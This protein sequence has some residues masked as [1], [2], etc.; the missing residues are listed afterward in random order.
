M[1]I[2]VSNNM[3]KLADSGTAFNTDTLRN[4]AGTGSSFPDLL[5]SQI[6]PANNAPSP[7]PAADVARARQP[8][9]T[10]PHEPSHAPASTS[11]TRQD[12]AHGMPPQHAGKHGRQPVGEKPQDGATVPA[13]GE[14]CEMVSSPG[15][16]VAD[17]AAPDDAIPDNVVAALTETPTQ[18]V[19]TVVTLVLP[20]TIAALPETLAK[21][22][23]ADADNP[24]AED[25][26]ITGI[27]TPPRNAKRHWRAAMA[28]NTAADPAGSG[29]TG[30]TA[31]ASMT[32]VLTA[33]PPDSQAANIP[34][35]RA[36]ALM[37][38][39][40][41]GMGAQTAT[42][43]AS[44]ASAPMPNALRTPT[45]E[46]IAP[47]RF[48]IPSTTGQRAWAEEVGNKIMWMLGR[49][50]SRAELI[51]TPPHLGRVEVSINLNGDQTTAQ[52][53]AS[54]QTAREALEQAMPRLRELLAQAGIDLGSASVDTSAEGQARDDD[55]AR[56]ARHAG[57]GNAGN[58]DGN[59]DAT[60]VTSANWTRLD[61]GLIDTFA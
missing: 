28:S 55:T 44:L 56:A 21:K 48:A 57:S 49:A 60:G 19:D 4:D 33:P 13:G 40:S 15:D 43:D 8:D 50:E 52:F 42:A 2:P 46:S 58:D 3:S 54:S 24:T 36:D 47:L 41:A 51:L 59:D 31:N 18:T 35:P 14:L 27:E 17:D 11:S 26:G 9:R 20:A 53:V 7:A 25:T 34:S 39:A 22:I 29:T 38:S 10:P 45:Q 30:K 23:L 16:T 1:A 12:P 6:Q 32:S 61:N 37:A 5:R